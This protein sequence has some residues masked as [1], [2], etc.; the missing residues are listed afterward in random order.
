MDLRTLQLQRDVHVDFSVQA[1][2]SL[3][4]A[5]IFKVTELDLQ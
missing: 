3:I 4:R 1:G 2:T 5:Q